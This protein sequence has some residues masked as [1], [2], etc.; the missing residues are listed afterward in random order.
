MEDGVVLLKVIKT[1]EGEAPLE[2]RKQ[3]VGLVLPG[4]PS[5]SF[6]IGLESK[7]RTRTRPHYAVPRTQAIEALK[8]AGRFE[9]VQ[10]FK[11]LA[12]PFLSF[13]EDEVISLGTEP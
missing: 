1:P 7:T 13:G 2:I 5:S 11:S 4:A 10:Y 12:V 6:E 8:T 3:W 9:A